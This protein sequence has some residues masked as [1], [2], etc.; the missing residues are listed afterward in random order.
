MG[1]EHSLEMTWES[2]ATL[3]GSGTNGEGEKREPTKKK[4][5]EKETSKDQIET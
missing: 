1:L 4:D 2:P 3:N 5:L